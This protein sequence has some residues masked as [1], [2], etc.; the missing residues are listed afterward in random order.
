MKAIEIIKYKIKS[1]EED[2]RKMTAESYQITFEHETK[3]K[4]LKEKIK[5]YEEILHELQG[6]F[7]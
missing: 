3:V 1:L 2:L 7:E 4:M 5:H 6:E